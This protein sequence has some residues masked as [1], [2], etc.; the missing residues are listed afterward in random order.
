MDRWRRE[1]ADDGGWLTSKLVLMYTL[2]SWLTYDSAAFIWFQDRCL[3]RGES[4]SCLPCT[5]RVESLLAMILLVCE[6]MFC[7][8][9]FTI[10]AHSD[11]KTSLDDIKTFRMLLK[12]FSSRLTQLQ[13]DNGQA[14]Q[15]LNLT[16]YERVN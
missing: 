14:N 13:I 8:F 12:W 9:I 16:T 15:D 5:S 3:C 4:A 10:H 6:Q 1:R 2:L 7:I 11:E